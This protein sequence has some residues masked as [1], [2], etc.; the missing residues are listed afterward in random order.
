MNMLLYVFPVP[1]RTLDALR[2]ASVDY[3][4]GQGQTI[5]LATY[6]RRMA[7]AARAMGIPT[8]DLTA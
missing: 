2:L 8:I 1:V 3:L 6:D 4:H 5:E 7:N